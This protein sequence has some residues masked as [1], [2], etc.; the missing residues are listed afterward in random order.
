MDEANLQLSAIGF[1]EEFGT[2]LMWSTWGFSIIHIT[3]LATYFN[4]YRV[5]LSSSRQSNPSGRSYQRDIQ[6]RASH[7]VL[8]NFMHWELEM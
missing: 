7:D 6:T 5:D 8:Q 3:Q 4:H 2:L 1:V